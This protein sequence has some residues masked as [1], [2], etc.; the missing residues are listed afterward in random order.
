MFIANV[1]T[2]LMLV[3]CDPFG[4]V[5]LWGL[6]GHWNLCICCAGPHFYFIFCM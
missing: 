4:V 3:L 1:L 2:L 5:G 6:K